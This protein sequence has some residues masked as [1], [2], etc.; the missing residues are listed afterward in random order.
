MEY[1]KAIK[2]VKGA[3]ARYRALAKKWHP[4]RNGSVNAG[5][6]MAEINRQ[7]RA[8]LV[9]LESSRDNAEFGGHINDHKSEGESSFNTDSLKTD[10]VELSFSEYARTAVIN[11]VG[12][13]EMS[14]IE[15]VA[16]KVA[17]NVAESL[18]DFGMGKLR[19]WMYRK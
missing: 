5:A 11:A 2:T 9:W 10:R 3:T 19:H 16:R 12:D 13:K 14:E 1:F 8:I 18:V 17:T 7:Y 4:D 6:T 15:N